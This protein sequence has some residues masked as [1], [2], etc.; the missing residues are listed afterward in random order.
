M[1]K[2][3]DKKENETDFEYGLRLI[4]TKVEEKPEDLEWGDIVELLGLDIHKDTLRKAASVSPYSGYAVLKYFENKEKNDSKTKNDIYQFEQMKIQIRDERNELNKKIRELSRNNQF[5]D[6]FKNIIREEVKPCYT[7]KPKEYVFSKSDMVVMLSDI[8]YG[9]KCDNFYNYYDTDIAADRLWKY[10]DEIRNIQYEKKSET[11]YLFLG[12]D[13]IS[14]N[15]HTLIRIENMVNVVEQVRQVSKL[16]STFVYE[17]SKIFS[18]VEVYHCPGNHSRVIPKKEDNQKG[19]YLDSLIPVFIESELQNLG[20]LVVHTD[21]V[22]DDEICT[23]EVRGHKFVGVHGHRDSLTNV[24]TN[25]TRMIH[26]IPDGILMGHKHSNGLN[27]V[28]KTKV[29]QCGCLS[30]VDSHC[31]EQRYMGVPEQLVFTVTNKK[32]IDTFYDIQF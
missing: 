5:I 17:L 12:G 19:D 8:H 1:N 22:Y 3:Y 9:L 24:L 25:T 27:T 15:I 6:T 23:F 11:C 20:N 14:G 7:Y 30:G 32:I 18:K 13:L 28:D 16:L 29:I 21:N 26:Y 2:L 10:L 31:I 4:K